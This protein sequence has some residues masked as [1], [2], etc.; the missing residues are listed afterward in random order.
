MSNFIQEIKNHNIN[1]ALNLEMVFRTS[2][3]DFNKSIDVVAD[4]LNKSFLDGLVDEQAVEIDFKNL[5]I[6]LEKA[7]PHKYYRREGSPGNYKYYYTKEEYEKEKKGSSGGSKNQS[8]SYTEEDMAK[9][10]DVIIDI[11]QMVDDSVYQNYIKFKGDVPESVLK[12]LRTL[13]RNI[14]SGEYDEESLQETDSYKR[15]KEFLAGGEFTDQKKKVEGGKEGLRI[16]ESQ[17]KTVENKPVGSIHEHN[18]KKYKKQSNGKWVEVSEHGMTKKE[19]EFKESSH[20]TM[21]EKVQHWGKAHEENEEKKHQEAASKLSDKEYD[22]TDFEEKES[23]DSVKV[24]LGGDKQLSNLKVGDKLVLT[25]EAK[26]SKEDSVSLNIVQRKP[27]D[28]YTFIGMAGGALRVKGSDGDT[29]I[30]ASE[31][32]EKKENSFRS[33]DHN[34]VSTVKSSIRRSLK[35]D[36]GHNDADF[37]WIQD[38]DELLL[39]V[40]PPSETFLQEFVNVEFPKKTKKVSSTHIVFDLKKFL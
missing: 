2:D 8:Q 29:H 24:Y 35:K 22:D 36:I 1:K 18:G 37:E 40:T 30:L 14:K 10:E 9:Y 11:G 13:R 38:K 34:L 12:D 27:D 28:T 32:F 7:R 25:K 21:K 15:V 33:V 19:H 20:R 39:T 6:I 17:R 5:D 26:N 23:G 3:E 16:N 31:R 4:T